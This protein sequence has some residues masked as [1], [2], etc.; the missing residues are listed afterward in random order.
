MKKPISSQCDVLLCVALEILCVV[1]ACVSA[2]T[3]DP[4]AS[5]FSWG[6]LFCTLGMWLWP[7]PVLHLAKKFLHRR[8]GCFFYAWIVA[9]LFKL[10]LS[11]ISGI[12]GRTD[13][14]HGREG[15]YFPWPGDEFWGEAIFFIWLGIVNGCHSLAVWIA[16]AVMGNTEENTDA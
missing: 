14:W 6:D 4:A 7:L 10:L 15:S 1:G 5:G 11:A 2:A 8:R 9:Y 13:V 16:K 12:F 3:Y